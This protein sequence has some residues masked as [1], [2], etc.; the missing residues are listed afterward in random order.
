M[1]KLSQI[2]GSTQNKL[3]FFLSPL[4]TLFVFRLS[5]LRAK[6]GVYAARKRVKKGEKS[7]IHHILRTTHHKWR[8]VRFKMMLR[9]YAEIFQQINKFIFALFIVFV[10]LPKEHR[11]KMQ[12]RE[13]KSCSHCQNG[14]P[15]VRKKT[16]HHLLFKTG[17]S[18]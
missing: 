3:L 16:N 11:Q 8:R 5:T 6:E 10:S 13:L 17:P 4:F 12:R 14:A 15:R 2:G 9:R 18:V 1:E 7:K